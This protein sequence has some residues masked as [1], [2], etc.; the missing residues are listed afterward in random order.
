M[1]YKTYPSTPLN[2]VL[3]QV[4]FSTPQQA[5]DIVTEFV[6]TS[7]T[8]ADAGWGGY[9]YFYTTA[10]QLGFITPNISQENAIALIAPFFSFVNNATRAVTEVIPFDSFYTAFQV[11]FS[12]SGQVGTNVEL[13]S[14]LV[15]RTIIEQNPGK[16][17]ETLLS[18]NGVM[19]K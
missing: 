7:L 3:L 13:S 8:L 18:L 10:F 6:K 17:A 11:L 19:W 14:R 4:N 12:G 2:V 1:T 15:P 16:V 9:V 5:R